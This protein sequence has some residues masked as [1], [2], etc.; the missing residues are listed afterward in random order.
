MKEIYTVTVF[1]KIEREPLFNDPSKYLPT[2]GDRR[3]VGWYSNLPEADC[4]VTNN[5]SNI[6]T[7][8]DFCTYDYAII[9]KI[10][11]G[12]LMPDLE[13]ERVVYKWN[14]TKNQFEKIDTPVEL[15][16]CSNFGIG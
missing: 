3:C 5:F 15:S 16:T 11:S 13:R 1:Q 7:A 4:A 10:E 12:L 2:F 6:H 8:D 9:E 14:D